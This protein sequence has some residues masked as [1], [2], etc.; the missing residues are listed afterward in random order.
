MRSVFKGF[1]YVAMGLSFCMSA[2]ADQSSPAK[3]QL[4]A[5]LK[6][7][8]DQLYVEGK[9]PDG[10]K[11]EV[12]DSGKIIKY[13]PSGNTPDDILDLKKK[14][15]VDLSANSCNYDGRNMSDDQLK[16]KVNAKLPGDV[17]DPRIQKCADYVSFVA[18]MSD[19]QLG[20]FKPLKLAAEGSNQNISAGAGSNQ[21]RI[22]RDA[23]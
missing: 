23:R 21:A 19:A 17:Y 18:S 8:L 9:I 1:V 22:A 6:A 14:T 4:I 10:K 13:D 15:E 11:I 7:C 2:S 16:D 20:E 3:Q 5:K 12:T